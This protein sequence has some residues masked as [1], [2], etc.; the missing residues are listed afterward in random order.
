MNLSTSFREVLSSVE[1]S[2]ARLKHIYS[3]LCALTWRPMPA[4][5][6]SKVCSSVS[7]W[8]G[9]FASIAMSLA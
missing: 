7:A 6:H 8:L 1:M 2:P 5:A 4:A 9:V 3:V